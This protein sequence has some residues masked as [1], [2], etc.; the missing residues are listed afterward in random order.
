MNV[1]DVEAV[2]RLS[3][4]AGA[5]AGLGGIGAAIAVSPWFAWTGNALSDLG[6]PARAS[7]PL[8]NGGLVVGGLLG[9]AFAGYVLAARGHPVARIGA[10]IVGV[11]LANM[12]LV[13]VFDVTHRLHGTVAVAFFLAITYGWFVHGTGLALAGRVRY[14][15]GTIW[16]GVI[17]VSGWLAWAASGIE[18]IA[19]PETLG[20]LLLATWIVGETRDL[21][22]T[23]LSERAT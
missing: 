2:W 21:D 23:T 4:I 18:G 19:L 12:A 6:H 3:G 7:A 22:G 8:F 16:L 10:A 5:V 20:A 9:V 1:P 13:G 14:G 15:V 17:H 11:G